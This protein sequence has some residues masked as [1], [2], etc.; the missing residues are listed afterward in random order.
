MP[1]RKGT[2]QTP[3]VVIDEIIKEHQNGV[4][5]RELSIKYDKPLKTIRNMITKENHKKRNLE[6]GIAPKKLADQEKHY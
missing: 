3:Q 1:C 6:K 5:I 2:K 4:I